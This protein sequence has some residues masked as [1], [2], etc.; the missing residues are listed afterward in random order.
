MMIELRDVTK[1]YPSEQ[2]EVRALDGLSLSVDAG[3]FVAVRG[4]SGSGKSTLLS[5]IGGLT[6]PTSGQV[7]VAGQPVSSLGSSQRAKFRET[8]IGFVFQMFHL[9]PYL[10][11]VDNILLAASHADDAVRE[12]AD[13]LIERFGLNDRRSHRPSQLSAGERQR[14]AMARALLN[15]PRLLLADEPTGNLDP[16][17]AGTLLDMLREFHSAGGTVLLVTHDNFAADQS[18]RIVRLRQGKLD[19]ALAAPSA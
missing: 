14:V 8:H 13:R 4:P 18:Q 9:L 2:G 3:E 5:L 15:Q 7:I 16:E 1:T 10:S 17:N 6:L 12:R 11:I 19:E